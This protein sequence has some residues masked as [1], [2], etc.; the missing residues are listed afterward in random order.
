[1]ESLVYWGVGLL[2]LAM[3]M[4]MVEVFVPTAGVLGVVS[5]CVAIAGIVCL[6]RYDWR[7]GLSGLLAVAVIGPSIVFVGL[8]IFPSTPFGKKILNLPPEA[9]DLG[10]AGA[11]PASPYEPLVGGEADAVT[12][13]RPSGFVRIDGKR[14][15]ALSEVSFVRAGAKV[16]ITAAD[17]MQ[18]RVRPTEM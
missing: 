6:F 8:Q 5:A 18:V 12:D 2:A 10:R 17:A 14:L 16:R 13:L 9:E 1:M 7:W 4:L 11:E 15:P 3:L